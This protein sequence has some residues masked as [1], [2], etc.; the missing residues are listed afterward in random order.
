MTLLPL[1]LTAALTI[2]AQIDANSDTVTEETTTAASNNS[3]WDKASAFIKKGFKISDEKENYVL[4]IGMRVHFRDTFSATDQRGERRDYGYDN[5]FSIPAAKLTLSGNLFGKVL[6]YAVEGDFGGGVTTIQDCFV[7]LAF[8]PNK[9]HLKIGQWKAPI[10]RQS[11]NSSG[12]LELTE[13]VF[14]RKRF[15]AINDMGLALHNNYTKSPRWEWVVGFLYGSDMNNI[16]NI[17]PRLTARFGYNS[18]GMDS[19]SESDF[20][21]GALRWSLAANMLL[22]FDPLE[23][24]NS[25]V[26]SSIDFMLKFS[27][28][29]IQG[30]AFIAS[31]QA[32]EFRLHFAKQT[33][34]E[35]AVYGQISYLFIGQLAPVYRFSLINTDKHLP[36]CTENALGLTWYV[37]N[38]NFKIQLMGAM[39]TN[40]WV[41]DDRVAPANNRNSIDWRLVSQIV[42]QI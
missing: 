2:P 21:G 5:D 29:S 12:R 23:G 38:H 37:V 10:Y 9:L 40:S 32:E 4:K 31:K 17:H 41:L 8:I 19:Y 7:D 20:E 35:S 22:E 15:G 42:F 1:L 33:Y 26:V 39:R 14:F 30:G 16:Q 6:Y 24:H 3:R 34:G 18:P 13:S 11:I 36:G 28:F 25:R 27:H